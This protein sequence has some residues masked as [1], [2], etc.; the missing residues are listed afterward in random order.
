VGLP[1]CEACDI[2]MGDVDRDGSVTGTDAVFILRDLVGLPVPAHH[3]I[4]KH[5]LEKCELQ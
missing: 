2:V 3:R 1:L 5:G 4:G